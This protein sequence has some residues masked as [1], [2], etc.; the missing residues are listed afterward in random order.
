MRGYSSLMRENGWK[1][2]FG[3]P[4]PAVATAMF[5]NV[6][7]TSRPISFPRLVEASPLN[8]MAEDFFEDDIMDTVMEDWGTDRD[9]VFGPRAWVKPRQR[10]CPYTCV[11]CPRRPPR[12]HLVILPRLANEPMATSNQ[13]CGKGIHASSN[14]KGKEQNSPSRKQTAST[15]NFSSDCVDMKDCDE[16]RA[17]TENGMLMVEGRGSSD[18]SRRMVRYIT[19]MPRHVSHDSLA[20]SLSNGRLT[21]TQKAGTQLEGQARNLPI[22]LQQHKSPEP[23]QQQQQQQQS[24]KLAPQK[25]KAS[26]CSDQCNEKSR[27]ATAA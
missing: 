24:T 11:T 12:Q 18:T 25:E 7:L 15:R 23:E 5:S 22:D 3:L 1:T 20:A 27:E 4:I 19:S 16:V 9:F 13:S 21:V 17:T 2:W 10:W 14:T 6:F 8:R 26:P